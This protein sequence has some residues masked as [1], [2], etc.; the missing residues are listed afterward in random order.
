MKRGPAAVAALTMILAGACSSGEEPKA[1]PSASTNARPSTNVK[2]RVLSP[3]SGSTLKGKTVTVKLDLQGGA[4]APKASTNLKPNEGH[5]HVTLDNKLSHTYGLEQS[6]NDVLPGLHALRVE[7][8]AS[9][10]VPF[11][12][13]LIVNVGFTTQA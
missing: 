7:F 11:N 9:D 10:H 4:I 13:R 2:L 6:F 12:P 8:V 1:K 5:I 3:E